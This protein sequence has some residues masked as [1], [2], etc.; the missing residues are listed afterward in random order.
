MLG[1]L[2]VISNPSV[3]RLSHRT[4]ELFLSL[5]FM[6]SMNNSQRPRSPNLRL[7]TRQDQATR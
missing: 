1:W 3:I 6:L 4:F 2:S 5:K 7:Q